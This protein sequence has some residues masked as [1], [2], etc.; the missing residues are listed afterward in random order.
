MNTMKKQLTAKRQSGFTLIELVVVI[1]ILGVLTAIAVPMISSALTTSK[2]RSYNAEEER[3][4]AA[5]DAFYSAPD[6]TRFIGKRQYPVIGRAQT[7]Q[8]LTNLTSTT[9]TVADD[10]S[11]FDAVNASTATAIWNPV[12]GTVGMTT[13]TVWTDDADGVREQVSAGSDS[14]DQWTTVSVTRGG[15]TYYTDPRYF[16]IDFEVLL[17]DGL[18]KDVPESASPDNAPSGSTRTYTGAY[19]WYVDDQGGVRSLYTD[20]PSTTTYVDG[21][22]P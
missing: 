11:P 2:D 12:G 9:S 13:S 4:Q 15:Q 20:F 7:S 18:L 5:V 14:V 10:G 19:I 6:N 16:F 8:S 3:I 17:T 1:A 21:V 22:F